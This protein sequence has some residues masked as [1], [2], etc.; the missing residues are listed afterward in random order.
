[1]NDDASPFLDRLQH[2]QQKTICIRALATHLAGDTDQV[3]VRGLLATELSSD[4]GTRRFGITES[5]V[6]T[7]R[8]DDPLAVVARGVLLSAGI[9]SNVLGLLATGRCE[10]RHES[11]QEAADIAMVLLRN[12]EYSEV[13]KLRSETDR[14]YVGSQLHGT[15]HP[16]L[17]EMLLTLVEGVRQPQ[18]SPG[19]PSSDGPFRPYEALPVAWACFDIPSCAPAVQA[20]YDLT[21]AMR[22]WGVPS[23]RNRQMFSTWGEQWALLDGFV[24][25]R[26]QPEHERDEPI[27]GFVAAGPLVIQLLCKLGNLSLPDWA[28]PYQSPIDG[29]ERTLAWQLEYRRHD[30]EARLEALRRVQDMDALEQLLLEFSQASADVLP[31]LGADLPSALVTA[32]K[33]AP[34]DPTDLVMRFEDRLA[35]ASTRSLVMGEDRKWHRL[36]YPEPC[37]LIGQIDYRAKSGTFAEES[38]SLCPICFELVVGFVSDLDRFASTLPSSAPRRQIR[39]IAGLNHGDVQLLV[40]LIRYAARPWHR[41]AESSTFTETGVAFAPAGTVLETAFV[42]AHVGAALANALAWCKANNRPAS[43]EMGESP[44]GSD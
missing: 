35:L 38:E 23:T 19:M 16:K 20:F 8:A 18:A 43:I 7:A 13:V 30:L 28:E 17:A 15:L 24:I 31:P 3:S 27:N 9:D 4:G 11:G 2:E 42:P 34:S 40:D 12:G 5:P 21:E 26:G 25:Q 29:L 6:V 37:P 41:H 44:T 10:V 36:Q 14:Y 33:S 1:M 22:G 32:D 39:D